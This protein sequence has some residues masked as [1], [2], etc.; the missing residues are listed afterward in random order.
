MRNRDLAAG[1]GPNNK[2]TRIGVKICFVCKIFQSSSLEGRILA[3]AISRWRREAN[4]KGELTTSRIQ[5]RLSRC[6]CR[7]IRFE[8]TSFEEPKVGFLLVLPDY[9]IVSREINLSGIL[10]ENDI[11]VRWGGEGGWLFTRWPFSQ[12]HLCTFSTVLCRGDHIC[13]AAHF[14]QF[15]TTSDGIDEGQRAMSQPDGRWT[16]VRWSAT[17]GGH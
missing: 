10:T 13:A 14:V 17:R 15:C 6:Q 1:I 16:V 8:E 2:E 12:P 5:V 11:I 9:R 7:G 3:T 4:P